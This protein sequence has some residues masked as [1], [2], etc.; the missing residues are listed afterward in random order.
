MLTVAQDESLDPEQCAGV[1][2]SALINTQLECA[3][4]GNDE[5]CVGNLNVTLESPIELDIVRLGERVPL[6]DVAQVTTSSMNINT[7]EFGVML[8]RIALPDSDLPVTMIAFGETEVENLSAGLLTRFVRVTSNSGAFVRALPNTDADTLTPLSVGAEII[9]IGRLEDNSWLQVSL[10]DGQVGWIFASV[11]ESIPDVDDIALP[12]TDLAVTTPDDTPNRVFAPLRAMNFRSGIAEGATCAS[13]PESGLLIQTPDLDTTITLQI[14]DVLLVVRGT[15]FL[16][17]DDFASPPQIYA[18]EG[19]VNLFADEQ[20]RL[21][22]SA[23]DQGSLRD[24]VIRAYDYARMEILPFELL[25]RQF[26]LP[27][28]WLSVIIPAQ[29]NPLAGLTVEDD[30][31]VAVVNDVNVR[32]GPGTE[33]AVRGSMLATQSAYPTG[34]AIGADSRVWWRL[35]DGAWLSFDVTVVGGNCNDLPTVEVLPR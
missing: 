16:Q 25:L 4:S 14:N 18:L 15:A 8:T 17:A 20:E 24:G 22:I 33:Y 32:V 2:E 3:D 7:G 28:D 1:F 13:V 9:A 10:A 26:V 19:E 30:C 34:R 31:T 29:A 12:L 6:M 5:L 21:T 35:T 27:V 11:V 23:G